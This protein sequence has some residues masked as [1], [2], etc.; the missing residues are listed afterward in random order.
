[1]TISTTLATDFVKRNFSSFEFDSQP[2]NAHSVCKY[3]L[4]QAYV[5]VG[6]A[7]IHPFCL[8]TGSTSC[9]MVILPERLKADQSTLDEM[10]K[11]IDREDMDMRN[12]IAGPNKSYRVTTNRLLVLEKLMIRSG[13]INPVNAFTPEQKEIAHS[14]LIELQND[15]NKLYAEFSKKTYELWAIINK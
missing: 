1:M 9:M 10:L 15:L 3:H 2:K 11:R 5:T 13:K 4:R 7:D 14:K 8:D 6:C 12:I